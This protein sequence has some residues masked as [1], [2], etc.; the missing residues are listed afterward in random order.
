L[1]E[2]TTRSESQPPSGAQ[3]LR[4]VASLADEGR[5]RPLVDPTRFRLEDAPEAH[6]RAASGHAGKVVVEVS[7]A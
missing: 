1:R 3:I 4:H 6:R 5:V 7:A 2:R